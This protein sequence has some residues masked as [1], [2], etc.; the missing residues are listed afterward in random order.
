[1]VRPESTRE[2]LGAGAEQGALDREA[3][4]HR[5]SYVQS[6]PSSPGKVSAQC[7]LRSGALDPAQ[8]A[9]FLSLF[10]SLSPRNVP[11]DFLE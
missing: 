4:P 6:Y 5:P 3:Q 11:P 1:M 10:F 8:R 7:N 9:V 2:Q